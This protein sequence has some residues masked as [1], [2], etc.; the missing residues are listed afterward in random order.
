MTGLSENSNDKFDIVI[1]DPPKLAPTRGS[2]V[3]AKNKYVKINTA[4]LKLVKPGGLL[5]T[6]SC[7]AAVTQSNSLKD[8]V[9]EA[10][11]HAGRD[12]SY[13]SSMHAAKDHVVHS[14]YKEGEYLS[15]LICCVR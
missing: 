6:F 1:C 15:G 10:A 12:V 8:F 11:I 4:A 14:T 7:S 5:F 2:L 3:K 13:V 9:G